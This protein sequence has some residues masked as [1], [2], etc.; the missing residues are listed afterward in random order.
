MISSTG[1][2]RNLVELSL[3]N[4]ISPALA[5]A[6]TL[7][8]TE[9]VLELP[10]L[11]VLYIEDGEFLDY[12]V[13]PSL[14][15]INISRSP[16]SLTS[17]IDRSLCRLRKLT[18]IDPFGKVLPILDHAVT[19]LE[20]RLMLSNTGLNRL[21]SYLTIPSDVDDGFRPPCPTLHSI[22]LCNALDEHQCSL[23]VQMVESRLLSAACPNLS[24]RILNLGHSK[25]DVHV[26]DTLDKLRGRGTDVE[27]L[28]EKPARR[29]AFIDWVDEY[30]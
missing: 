12:L 25:L 22:S 4:S 14:E 26:V 9:S 13:L 29:R 1:S 17:L 2:A 30:P 8:L 23:F 10:H 24:C 19:L 5:L 11:R 21:L 16:S 28:A 20:M 15:D 6:R 27:W 3:T 7:G 18:S